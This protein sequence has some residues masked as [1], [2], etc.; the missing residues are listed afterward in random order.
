LIILFG[1]VHLNPG[2]ESTTSI[3]VHN[4]IL[5]RFSWHFCFASNLTIVHYNVQS[6]LCKRRHPSYW[7]IQY[8]HFSCYWNMVKPSH[9][10][11][12]YT[13]RKLFIT[14]QKRQNH[15]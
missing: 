6:F 15:W 12:N 3:W 1:D 13:L 2:P 7:A 11:I 8:W 10:P 4:Y 9:I 14:T 5:I